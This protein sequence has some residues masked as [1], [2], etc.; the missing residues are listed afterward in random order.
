MQTIERT[1]LVTM[2][3]NRKGCTVVTIK[4]VTDARLKKTGNDHGS[5][6]KIARVNG[7]IGWNYTNSVNNQR[8]REGIEAHFEAQPRKWGERIKGTPLVEY[9]GEYYLE[10]K[11]ERI[12]DITYVRDNDGKIVTYSEI[13]PFMPAKRKPT[14]QGTEKDIIVA[15]YKINNIEEI[16]ID[17]QEYKLVA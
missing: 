8:T 9:K 17:G 10:V 6:S 7:M 11:I 3:M 4:A 14:T 1:E 2:L 5:C 15:D 16:K 13:E 12:L